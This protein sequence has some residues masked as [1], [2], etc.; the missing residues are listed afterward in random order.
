[1]CILLV[2]LH[3]SAVLVTSMLFPCAWYSRICPVIDFS[4]DF[5]ALLAISDRMWCVQVFHR[6]LLLIQ[7]Y[8]KTLLPL[9]CSQWCSWYTVLWCQISW[10]SCSPPQWAHTVHQSLP[11]AFTYQVFI[12]GPL[13]QFSQRMVSL[14]CWWPCF[15]LG[16]Y[17]ALS[18]EVQDL[19]PKQNAILIS[20]IRLI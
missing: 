3:P 18:V 16:S 5:L 15:T 19:F 17:M 7:S 14:E 13:I 9:W 4:S 11:L 2:C 8:L 12:L 6:S 20:V 10:E 1:M